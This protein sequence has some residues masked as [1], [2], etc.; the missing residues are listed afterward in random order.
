MPI[1]PSLITAGLELGTQA[2]NAIFQ[3]FANRAQRKWNEKMYDQQ[4][5][6]ALED[7]NRQNEY[8]SPLQQMQRLKDAGLNPNLV[9]GNG[10]QTPSAQ[11]R[12]S[13]SKSWQP[14][15]PRFSAQ[16]VS[17]AYL[18]TQVKQAQIDLLKT[19]NTVQQRES[20]LKEVERIN[21]IIQGDRS[22]FDLEVKRELKPTYLDI[23]KQSLR[24]LTADADYTEAR[25]NWGATQNMNAN[26]RHNVEMAIRKYYRDN[27][28]PQEMK[29]LLQSIVNMK[30]QAGESQERVKYLTQQIENAATDGR[31]KNLTLELKKLGLDT[32]DPALLKML[33]Q[34]FSNL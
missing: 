23:Q 29:K 32:N 16:A 21:K 33:G 24:K 3:G 11:I 13:D 28:Q 10:A 31:I 27:M 2:T 22:K 17:G 9:Y 25:T 19:Q 8:N 6:H 15:A 7:W 14:Q 26:E 1:S 5:A 12:S 30:Q 20:A 4:R 34:F 18:D